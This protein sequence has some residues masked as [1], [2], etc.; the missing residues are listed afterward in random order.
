MSYNERAASALQDAESRLREIVAEAAEAGDYAA[1][2]KIATLA[3]AINN[4][5]PVTPDPGADSVTLKVST[6][7]KAN[8]KKRKEYP[9]F[10][11][12]GEVLVRTSWSKADKREYEHK[13]PATVLAS[14]IS[15]LSEVASDGRVFTTAELLPL[16][17]ADGNE[18]PNYQVYA[19][20]GFLKDVSVLDQHGRQ[21][22]SVAD[23]ATFRA[24]AENAFESLPHKK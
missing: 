14:M 24:A 3:R 4:L 16:R 8:P 12:R 21:G 20:I 13:A 5:A 2:L 22:Y 1:V 7:S 23:L 9:V 17:L 10:G 19:W 11:R 6:R 15:A 18:I